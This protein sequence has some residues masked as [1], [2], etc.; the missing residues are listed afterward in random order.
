MAAESHPQKESHP[1]K[2]SLEGM[3]GSTLAAERSAV[4]QLLEES[5]AQLYMPFDHLAR[6]EIQKAAPFFCAT[7]VLAT[8]MAEEDPAHHTGNDKLYQQRLFL[9]AALEMLRIALTVHQLLLQ[10]VNQQTIMQNLP[11][12]EEDDANQRSITG[13]IILT[14]DFCFTQSAILAAKTDNVQVVEIFSQTLKQVSEGIL[15]QLFAERETRTARQ[16][17]QAGSQQR[18]SKER[19]DGA[20][21][22]QTTE[23]DAALILCKAGIDGT[24]ALTILTPT[25]IDAAKALVEILLNQPQNI[26]N[27]AALSALLA[28]LPAAQ[29]QRWREVLTEAS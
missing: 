18:E 22:M 20:P 25:Q 1:L 19:P 29:R 26:S 3:L 14:G 13:S 12:E 16:V 5:I 7:T 10:R 8:C 6:A 21:L 24:A 2:D 9:G 28:T 23:Y 11:T 4:K 17:N 15:R 27:P